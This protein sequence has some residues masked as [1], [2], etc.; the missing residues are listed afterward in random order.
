MPAVMLLLI[1]WKRGRVEWRRDVVPLLPFFAFGLVLAMF[2]G[3]IETNF[4]RATGEEWELS[5]VQ[6]ILLAGN[7]IWFYA[8]K[9]IAPVKLT[10]LYP[11][12]ELS[13]SN[14]LL[15][16]GVIASVATPVVLFLL[17]RRIGRGPLVAWLIFCGVLVP[18]LGFFNVYPMRYSY[19]ADH[20][21]YLASAGLIVL[22]VAGAVLA[23]RRI[24]AN[25]SVVHY[26]LAGLVLVVL[27]GLTI[28]Q[29]SIYDSQLSLWSDTAKKNPDNPS[30]RH[31]HGLALAAAVGELAIDDQERIARMLDQAAGEFEAATAL[32]PQHEK[33]WAA[34]G[35]VLL[36]R[37]D[38][39]Q[40]MEKFEKSLA[41]N[42]QNVDALMGRGKALVQL[43]M[44]PEALTAYQQ[45]L[46]AAVAQ[47]PYIPTI[48]AATIYQ[49]LGTIHDKLG[50]R[51]AAISAFKEAVRI[52]PGAPAI[53]YD[54]GTLLAKAGKATSQPATTQASATQPATTQAAIAATQPARPAPATPEQLAA[55][56]Q[57]AAAIRAAPDFID[58]RISL[59]ELMLEVGNLQGARTQL[60]AAA[61]INA[62]YPRLMEVARRFDAA[63]KQAEAATRPATTQVVTQ[64]S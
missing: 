49:M 35:Q 42:P 2:T 24:A 47:K 6:H 34:W 45:S 63:L 30:V 14:P 40:A 48:K 4:V 58:A 56:E 3:W 32:N 38:A 21:Q 10:F 15:W 9:L 23:L 46:Q 51:Q 22:I 44:W 52:S 28:A 16:L 39:K 61:H 54:F 50:N 25:S 62:A 26:V 53:H 1:W 20:F 36:E 59:A 33:A 19:V 43:K 64:P 12:W 27:T 17:R 11:K 29:S 8:G 18:A 7:A 37:H 41:I 55:A 57:F 31:N 5:I 13:A 60:I